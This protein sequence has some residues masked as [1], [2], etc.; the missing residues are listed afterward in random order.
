M[1]GRVE[2]GSITVEEVHRFPNG[3]IQRDGHLRWDLRRLYGEIEAG[4]NRVPEADSI[5]ID[6]WGVDY[7]LLDEYGTLLADPIS[8]RDSRGAQAVQ[9]V[10]ARVS[11]EELY[12]V[13]GIQFLA[14]NT[15]YQ[16][17]AEQE[18][19]LWPRAARAL[20]IPDLIAFWLTGQQGT[21]LTNAST[22]GLL[23]VNSR[24][25]STTILDR[26]DIRAELLA[27]LDSP[28]T[29]RGRTSGGTP[30]ISV[31]S[32]DTASAVAGIPAVMDNFAY[33]ASGTWSLVGL[34][35]DR[36]VAS[37]EARLANFTNE[38]GVDGQTRFL[39]NTGGF[40]LLDEC[41]RAW[42]GG[43]V[44]QLM[45]AAAVLP[46]G[47][48]FDVNDPGLVSPGAM[49]DKIAA[50]I[51]GSQPP[52]QLVRCIVDSLA[53]AYAATAWEAAGLA[54]RD[55]EVIHLVGGGARNPLLCQLTADT[56]GVP[57]VAGPVEA[58]ALGN[59]VVQARA[60]GAL[61]DSTAAV[62]SALAAST[63]LH[64]YLP[65]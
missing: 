48:R 28:G 42:G 6:A 29:E 32:H 39:R 27:P 36:P 23:D 60:H 15:I 62:R 50:R 25:W 20:L 45:G 30:V 16:L 63:V 47:P 2:D 37:E 61:P 18:T 7:G 57:V 34:E 12:A 31:G 4:L 19:P 24:T 38:V 40:W 53:D 65:R 55:I 5:G 10:H 54:E 14:F 21:E 13:T 52:S 9:G 3:V 59:A 43:D 22:T 64:R 58:T 11:P 33:V 49:P 26:L 41:L 1:A 44:D 51:G 56:A 46:P 8:Y 35:L 17:A